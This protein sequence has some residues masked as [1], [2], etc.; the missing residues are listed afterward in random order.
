M[1]PS[2]RHSLLSVAC[3]LA[4]GAHAADRVEL[5]DGSVVMGK[6]LSA[7]AGKL[8]LKT[9]FAGTIEIDQAKVRNFSTD[10]AVNVELAAGSTVQ[11]KVAPTEAS[12][13]VLGE[14]GTGKELV[15]Q[16]LHDMSPRRKGPF[17]PIN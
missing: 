16:T 13:F 6:L 2:I 7:E 4:L 1:K 5:T 10:E 12:V 14:T 8:K 3:A 11:G 9:D 17:V 15:A